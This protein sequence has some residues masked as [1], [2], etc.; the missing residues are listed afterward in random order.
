MVDKKCG[1]LEKKGIAGA[2]FSYIF[3][4]VLQNFF[5]G[6]YGK[7]FC[8]IHIDLAYFFPAQLGPVSHELVYGNVE[9]RSQ[10]GKHQDIRIGRAGFPF[11]DSRFRYPQE[12]GQLFLGDP[13]SAAVFR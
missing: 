2:V 4:A 3:P 13:H 8:K 10:P 6:K 12:P 5:K 1:H 9:K 7:F 11:G